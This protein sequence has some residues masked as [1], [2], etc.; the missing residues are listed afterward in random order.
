M[1]NTGRRSSKIH[2]KIGAGSWPW[3]ILRVDPEEKEASLRALESMH[4]VISCAYSLGH[5]PRKK[6]V[7][8]D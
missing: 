4:M 8:E 1:R 6:A 3:V 2:L 5:S 7:N